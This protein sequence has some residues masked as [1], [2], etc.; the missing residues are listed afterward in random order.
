MQLRILIRKISSSDYH[1]SPP[2]R[3][4]VD[5][6]GALQQ[7]E[8]KPSGWKIKKENYE[9]DVLNRSDCISNEAVGLGIVSF[10]DQ[11]LSELWVLCFFF[12]F[13][14]I[15]VSVI[16]LNSL[17]HNSTTDE[18]KQ[19]VSTGFRRFAYSPFGT[20]CNQKTY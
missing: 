1:P 16:L 17:P 10:Q 5:N 9:Y 15:Q 11:T 2:P 14:L 18:R 6:Q 12:C 19:Y 4:F 20:F 13:F 8:H 3:A 7:K